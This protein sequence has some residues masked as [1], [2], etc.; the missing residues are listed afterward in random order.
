[1]DCACNGW[2]QRIWI[3]LRSHKEAPLPSFLISRLI[4]HHG[5]QRNDVFVIH[6]RHHAD[7]PPRLHADAD[8]FHHAVCPSQFAIQRVLPGKECLREALAYND[9]AFGAVLVRVSEVTALQNR[10]TQRLEIPWRYRSK[11]CTPIIH[12]VLPRGSLR[13]EG[14]ADVQSLIVTPWG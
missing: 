12:S 2:C 7:N 14:E 5:R 4:H 3:L 8:K 6:I 1:M 10:H 9:H 13:C 11:L